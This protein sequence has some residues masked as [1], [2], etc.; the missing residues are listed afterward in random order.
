MVPAA[1]AHRRGAATGHRCG[2]EHGGQGEREN[3]RTHAACSAG[4][5]RGNELCAVSAATALASV[6]SCLAVA[7]KRPRSTRLREVNAGRR[8][9]P[10]LGMLQTHMEKR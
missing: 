9:T 7:R 4:G 3:E 5:W 2:D 1:P 10:A 8:A 6:R